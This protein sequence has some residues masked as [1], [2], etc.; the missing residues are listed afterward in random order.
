MRSIIT[1]KI[2]LG[3]LTFEMCRDNRISV[4][5][6]SKKVCAWGWVENVKKT[7]GKGWGYVGTLLK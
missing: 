4:R 6:K 3:K 7:C 2:S 5:N 1:S